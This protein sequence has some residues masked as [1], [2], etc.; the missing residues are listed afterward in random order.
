MATRDASDTNE[1]NPNT[2]APKAR[3]RE[4]H[5][6]PQIDESRAKPGKQIAQTKEQSSGQGSGQS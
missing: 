3:Q 1:A 2:P 4:G 5:L 6:S